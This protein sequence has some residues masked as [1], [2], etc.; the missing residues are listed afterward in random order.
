MTA[1]EES[2]GTVVLAHD[3]R[4]WSRCAIAVTFLFLGTAAYDYVLTPRGDDRL[5]GLLASAATMAVIAYVMS[6]R[7]RFRVDPAQRR[8]DWEQGFALRMKRGSIPFDEVRD[9]T[10]ER[11]IGDQGVPSRRVILHLAG[12]SRMPVTVGYRPDGDRAVTL[13]A[14]MLRRALGHMGPGISDTARLLVDA[15]RNV[16]AVKRP[17]EDDGRPLADARKEIDGIQ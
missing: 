16:N 9:V 5:V 12:G 8:I 13:A 17:A 2:D 1:W 11:P 10:L 3:T 6:E 7:S 15:G 14:E 4:V